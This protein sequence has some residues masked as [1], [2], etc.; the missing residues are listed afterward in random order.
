MSQAKNWC[1]TLNNYND[2][3]LARID[4]L[5]NSEPKIKYLIYGK[6]T[7]DSGTPHLQGFVSLN[8]RLRLAQI[9]NIIGG[10]PHLETSRNVNAS[11]QYC[12]KDGQFVEFGEMGA[13]AGSRSDIE[14]FKDSVKAGVLD[15]QELRELHSEV[16]AKYTRFCN[17]YIQDNTPQVV[18]PDHPLKAW[19]QGLMNKLEQP[20]ERR[21]VIFVVDEQGNTGKSWF[22]H[23]FTAKKGRESQVLLPGRKADMAY[24]LRPGIKYL[25]LDAPRSKQGEYIQYD[26]LE[27]LKNGYVFSTKYES[28][29]KSFE[30]LHVIVNMNEMPD[31][32]K[33]SADRF[34]IIH[35]RSLIPQQQPQFILND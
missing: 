12:K 19:Q 21:R 15:F 2:D 23:W 31:K 1:F 24:A 14:A 26:F 32:T 22:A 20:A 10:N 25:F 18:V 8:V 29:V 35:I 4:G 11:I 5:I 34:D 13:G 3:D 28:R 6:E 17:D 27:D 16:F 7:G 33:L 9:K 30:P